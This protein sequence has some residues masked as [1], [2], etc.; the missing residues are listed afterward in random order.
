MNNEAAAPTDEE[1][2]FDEEETDP[3]ELDGF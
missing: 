3:E 1:L 2:N